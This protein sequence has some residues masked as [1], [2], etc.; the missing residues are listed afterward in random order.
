[1]WS[2]RTC[3]FPA[4]LK[5]LRRVCATRFPCARSSRER[6][7]Q[8]C[9]GDLGS[10]QSSNKKP[11]RGIG[12]RAVDKANAGECTLKKLLQRGGRSFFPRKPVCSPHGCGSG[13]PG[14]VSRS[15]RDH[16]RGAPI[17]INPGKT[18]LSLGRPEGARVAFRNRPSRT[19]PSR[20]AT[21]R[22]HSQHS[23][24]G[25]HRISSRRAQRSRNTMWTTA[26]P[27]CPHPTADVRSQYAI[28]KTRQSQSRSCSPIALR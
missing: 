18:R 14:N 10:R 23:L 15:A 22:L 2:R 5:P 1:M 6:R 27:A 8:S 7:C 3:G 13:A 21:C 28:S 12:G 25:S 17:V 9:R 4:S 16:V 24:W 11:L 26:S 20:S 19:N